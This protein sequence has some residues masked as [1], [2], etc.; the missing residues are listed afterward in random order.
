MSTTFD[1][2]VTQIVQ[3]VND[4]DWTKNYWLELDYESGDVQIED[5]DPLPDCTDRDEQNNPCPCH[6]VLKAEFE[7][8]SFELP[9]KFT[10][11]TATRELVITHNADIYSCLVGQEIA[12]AILEQENETFFIAKECR[13]WV[14][15]NP[16]HFV[17]KTLSFPRRKQY[18]VQGDLTICTNNVIK[19]ECEWDEWIIT[20]DS[21]RD[22]LDVAVKS[23]RDGRL[24]DPVEFEWPI[25]AEQHAAIRE[26][27]ENAAIDRPDIRDD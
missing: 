7:P 16:V 9:V 22:L 3:L 27:V 10:I 1:N 15:E 26:A 2:A 24:P 5:W 11:N 4:F 19:I 25:T 23:G 6:G 12:D 17:R 13:D 20:Y 21:G 14:V 18:G 8:S